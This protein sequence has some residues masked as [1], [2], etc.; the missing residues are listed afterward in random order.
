MTYYLKT[1]LVLLFAFFAVA[2]SASA[3]DFSVDG[4]CYNIVDENG[5]KCA[6]V[7][8]GADRQPGYNGRIVI[9]E[10]VTYQGVS[11]KVTSIDDL[12]FYDYDDLT[13]VV[14]PNSLTTIGSE[15]FYGCKNLTAIE[16]P[17]SLTKIDSNAFTDCGFTSIHIPKNVTSLYRNV[18][19]KCSKLRTITVDPANTVYDSRDNCNAIINKE[20]ESIV[21]G[22]MNSFV[23]SGVFHIDPYAFSGCIG[24]THLDLPSGFSIIN[25]GAF[26]GCENLAT[27]SFPSAV[28]HVGDQAFADCKSLTSIHIPKRL[29]SIGE[30]PF[31]G[32]I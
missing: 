28:W 29:T 4:I 9:P 3:Y 12:S 1:R 18:F 24:L 19:S 11:Y 6:Q 20:D 31:E 27:I 16:L 26:Y 25:F 32:C 15:A 7:T 2:G 10:T 30:N 13:S 8:Q 22:C 17:E 23:P 5:T 21:T 14:L